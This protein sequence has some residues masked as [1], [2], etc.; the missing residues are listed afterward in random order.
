MASPTAASLRRPRR[1]PR[2]PHHAASHS[3]STRYWCV[4]RGNSD[5]GCCAQRRLQCYPV[6][7]VPHRSSHGSITVFYCY[8]RWMLERIPRRK[9]WSLS[10][11]DCDPFFLNPLLCVWMEQ[12]GTAGLPV[13]PRRWHR[14]SER[15]GKYPESGLPGCCRPPAASFCCAERE[16]GGTHWPQDE[17]SSAPQRQCRGWRLGSLLA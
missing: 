10:Q 3:L 5:F 17:S 13:A 15:A 1:A 14:R 16:A 11:S 8:A 12:P 7:C 6:L 2:R 9:M 4:A